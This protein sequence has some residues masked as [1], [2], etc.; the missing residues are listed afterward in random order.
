MGSIEQRGPNA[1]RLI[2][3][4]GLDSEGKQVKKTKTVKAKD[5]DEAKELLNQFENE[6]EGG[7]VHDAH[8]LSFEKFVKLHWLP[9][10]AEKELAPKTLYRYKELLDKR[11]YDG[12]G[13]LK[14]P[15]IRPT[16]IM[17]FIGNLQED[18]IRLDNKKVEGGKLADR[19]VL[20]HFRLISSILSD[21]V[22]WQFIPYNPCDRVKPPKVKKTEPQFYD[23]DSLFAML[24]ALEGEKIQHRTL[25]RVALALGTRQGEVY[26]LEWRDI[27]LD[28]G[29][30]RIRQQSQYLPDRG[31][32]E[33]DPKSE[34]SKRIVD[35]PAYVVQLLRDYQAWQDERKK[36]LGEKWIETGRV[37]T[38]WNGN[39]MLPNYMS[40]WFPKFLDH[41]GLPKKRFHSLRHTSATLSLADGV[42]LTN[43]SEKLGHA[44]LDTTGIYVHALRRL[45]KE[46]ATKMDERYKKFQE[47]KGQEKEQE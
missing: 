10:Y 2:V 17:E 29:L 19:T 1:W 26:G 33:K 21:A 28:E 12:I 16:H 36:K 8:R 40:S 18:N 6:I 27:N 44:D 5:E 9:K 4:C 14:L 42:P 38:T 11:I 34:T 45:N 43:V 30:L 37:F 13:H 15:K 47:K 39:K 23:E 31:I 22:E 41:H 46:M 3:S 24:N 25:V 7:L 35:L 20:G 32:F